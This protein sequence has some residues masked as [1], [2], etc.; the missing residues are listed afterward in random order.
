MRSLPLVA[1]IALALGI[2]LGCGSSAP[3]PPAPPPPA[4]PSLVEPSSPAP[5]GPGLTAPPVVPSLPP[6]A[7]TV[8]P[9]DPSR[10]PFRKLAAAFVEPAPGGGWRI[11]QQAALELEKLEAEARGP[12]LLLLTDSDAAVR[13]GAAFFLLNQFDADKPAEQQALAALISDSD[14]AVRGIALQAAWKFRPADRGTV[15][16]AWA[17]RLNPQTEPKPEHR[18]S[19]ARLIAGVKTE[20]AAAAPQLQTAVTSDPDPR[21]RGAALVALAET[22]KP[23]LV[24]SGCQAALADELPSVRIVAAARLRKLGASA[25]PAAKELAQALADADSAVRLAA[26]ET[27]VKIGAPAVAEVATQLSSK[28]AETRKLSVA[29]LASLGP[30]AKTA[31]PA[32]RPLL[33]DPVAE[34]RTAAEQALRGLGE[35]IDQKGPP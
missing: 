19:L 14:E 13:R 7:Q 2:A 18:A 23:E 15:A 25:T 17:A 21:V 34:I 4:T 22:A 27:L 3:L 20:A 24:I 12:M 31:A 28:Q 10:E 30:A 35:P 8:S 6:P 16:V 32:L 1:G 33:A 26:A 9:V 5:V 29:C 11:N